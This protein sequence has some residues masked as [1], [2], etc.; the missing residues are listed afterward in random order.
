MSNSVSGLAGGAA[1]APRAHHRPWPA[2][3]WGGRRKLQWRPCVCSSP[4]EG[5]SPDTRG[6]RDTL[7]T[8]LS[9]PGQA[10][11]LQDKPWG[12]CP[13]SSPTA[14]A[15]LVPTWNPCFPLHHEVSSFGGMSMTDTMSPTCK[16]VTASATA[17]RR[18]QLQQ[19]Q[20]EQC[21]KLQNPGAAAHLPWQS[22]AV[23]WKSLWIIQHRTQLLLRKRA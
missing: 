15:E 13:Y 23:T 5:E 16:T 19:P 4:R 14:V 20:S 17:R 22:Q 3:P 12:S 18:A 8:P 7:P 10:E 21:K 11:Q 6:G 9:H 2:C 1:E